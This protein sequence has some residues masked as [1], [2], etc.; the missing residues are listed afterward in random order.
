MG[1]RYDIQ[2]YKKSKSYDE[3]VAPR[4]SD[5]YDLEKTRFRRRFSQ[6]NI[7][8][9]IPLMNGS[10]AENSALKDTKV[11]CKSDSNTIDEM[12]MNRSI[13]ADEKPRILSRRS[14]GHECSSPKPQRN[15]LVNASPA[16]GI[17]ISNAK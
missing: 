13:K 14:F 8:D 4:E 16:S 9:I 17:C 12:F 11:G 1:L 2:P 6:G 15:Y 7:L 3:P 10:P 5:L